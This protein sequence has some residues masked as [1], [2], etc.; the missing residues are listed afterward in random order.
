MKSTVEYLREQ[1]PRVAGLAYTAPVYDEVTK[2]VE[3]PYPAACV[4]MGDRC[5]CYSQQATKLDVPK[6]LCESIVSGGFY[7]AW[8][9]KAAPAMRDG[10]V[11]RP[12]EP[13]PE[14]PEAQPVV[15]ITVAEAVQGPGRGR[16]LPK[17]A[18]P[19]NVFH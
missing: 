19:A 3:A 17:L 8:Q 18:P 16:A 4:K 6:A 9:T 13:R 14:L 10:V 7:V 5:G 11:T 2:P 1:Q 12:P 15:P